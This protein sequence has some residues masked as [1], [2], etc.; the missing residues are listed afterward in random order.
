MNPFPSC[1]IG[2]AKEGCHCNQCGETGVPLQEDGMCGDCAALAAF[3]ERMLATWGVRF[4]GWIDVLY[5]MMFE[6]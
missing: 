5:W 1:P 4:V 6:E 2:C 3:N